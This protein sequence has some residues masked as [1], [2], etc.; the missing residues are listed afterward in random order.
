MGQIPRPF[1]CCKMHDSSGFGWE[2]LNAG[3]AAK[4]LTRRC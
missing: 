1:C 2:G 3:T 4:A